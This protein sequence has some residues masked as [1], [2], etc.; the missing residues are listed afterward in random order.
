MK[1]KIKVGIAQISP[2]WLNQKETLKKVA[3]YITKAKK[4]KCSLVTFGEAMVPGYP[5]W[6][7]LTNGAKFE[8]D[9]QK[10]LYAHYVS[11]AISVEGGDLADICEAARKNKIEV[12]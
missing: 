9:V 4:A 12:I 7:E 6:V 11:Q 3:K 5:F 1:Q 8:S 2:V 10:D